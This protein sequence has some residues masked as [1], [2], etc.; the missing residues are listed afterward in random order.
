MSHSGGKGSPKPGKEKKKVQ[1]I[2]IEDLKN[3][4]DDDESF[5][6]VNAVDND[7]VCAMD[8]LTGTIES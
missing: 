4:I 5:I 8:A 6:L 1:E 3:R 7:S 2:T